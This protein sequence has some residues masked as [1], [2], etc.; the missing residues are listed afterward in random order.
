MFFLCD[1]Y[2]RVLI[3]LVQILGCAAALGPTAVSCVSAAVQADV[4]M[5]SSVTL[6]PTH[7]AAT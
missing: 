1:L 7:P 6:V 4:G 2:P 5:F 3:I